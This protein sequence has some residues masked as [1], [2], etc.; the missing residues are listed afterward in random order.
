V[1]PWGFVVNEAFLHATPV[2]ASETVGAVAGRLVEDRVNG[3]VVPAG[4]AAALAA[5]CRELLGEPQLAEELGVNARQSVSAY[6][7]EAQAG[8]F[9]AA[10]EACGIALRT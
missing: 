5:A 4:E 7:H 10:L 2:V 6:T 1:E 8:G 3:L 9:E